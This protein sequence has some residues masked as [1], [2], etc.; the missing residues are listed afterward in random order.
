MVLFMEGFNCL[1]ATEPLQRDSLLFTTTVGPEKC[2]KLLLIQFCAYFLEN[3]S[4][5]VLGQFFLAHIAK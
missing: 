3:G 4:R 5:N 2:T 1:K